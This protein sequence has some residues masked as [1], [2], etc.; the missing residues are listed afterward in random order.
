[1]FLSNPRKS[2]LTV[3]LCAVLLQ[4]CGGSQPKENKD[5]SLTGGTKSEFPFSTKEPEVYEGDL[6]VGSGDVQDRYFVARKGDRWRC[7]V[8]RGADLSMSQIH[9]DKMYVIDHQKKTYWETPASGP[10]A[11]NVN[12]VTRNFFRGYDHRDFDEIGREGTLVKYKVRNSDGSRVDVIVTID[13][14]NGLMV[15]EEFLSPN[16]QG[17]DFVSEIKNLKMEVDDSVFDIPQGYK[18][19]ASK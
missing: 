13:T 8:F 5:I 18:K 3:A 11:D 2:F 19:V 6:M 16:K 9:L 17:S 14:A 1:M 7:D 15:K 4:A 10:A 12:D